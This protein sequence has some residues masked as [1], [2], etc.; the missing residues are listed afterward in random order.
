[1][2]Y[3]IIYLLIG[4]IITIYAVNDHIKNHDLILK[5]VIALIIVIPFWPM[6]P[7]T[8]LCEYIKNKINLNKVVIKG[9]ND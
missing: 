4:I 7:I 9:R 3:L 6:Y 2:M 1:M 5:D 8:F